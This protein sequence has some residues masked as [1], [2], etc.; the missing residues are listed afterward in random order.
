M[1]PFVELTFEVRTPVRV[2]THVL[3]YVAIVVRKLKRADVGF[4]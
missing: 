4:L 1:Q 3:V 2:K